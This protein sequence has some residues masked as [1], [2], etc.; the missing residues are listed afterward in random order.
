MIIFVSVLSQYLNEELVV[1]DFVKCEGKD[2]FHC[3]DKQAE[4]IS[5]D[6]ICN[7]VNECSTGRD[8]SVQECGKCTSLIFLINIEKVKSQKY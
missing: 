8:E 1:A 3:D 6:K 2:V 4:C 7:G 5:K